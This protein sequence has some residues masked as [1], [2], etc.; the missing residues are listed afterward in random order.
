MPLG[1]LSPNCPLRAS[2][3]HACRGCVADPSCAAAA[4]SSCWKLNIAR[5]QRLILRSCSIESAFLVP[6][7]TSCFF[8]SLP[9]HRPIAR[10]HRV[11]KRRCSAPTRMHHRTGMLFSAACLAMRIGTS[12]ATS[13][14]E[15]R[16][17]RWHLLSELVSSAARSSAMFILSMCSLRGAPHLSLRGRSKARG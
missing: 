5:R 7:V 4:A 15:G 17:L 8:P 2:Q 1:W 6:L 12:F 11:R 10:W 13:L 14:L 9:R 3:A 16:S